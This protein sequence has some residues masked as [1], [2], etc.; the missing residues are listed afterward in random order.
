M[1]PIYK[2]LA[3]AAMTLQVSLAL[4]AQTYDGE[5]TS[6]TALSAE[7]LDSLRVELVAPN[8]SGARDLIK[9]GECEI[10]GSDLAITLNAANWIKG[11]TYSVQVVATFGTQTQVIYALDV[12]V[13]YY[14]ALASDPQ[15]Y[16][17]TVTVVSTIGDGI[18]EDDLKKA[19]SLTYAQLKAKR[20]AGELV[21]GQYYRITDYVTT[22]A[23]YDNARSAGHAFD[24]IVLALSTDTLSEEA[25]AIQHAGDT[26]FAD[27]NLNG[28]KV[29][30]CIDNDTNRFDWADATNGKG[31]IYR[32]VDEYRNDMPFDFKNVQ[33]RRWAVTDVTKDDV[34]IGNASNFVYEDGSQDIRYGLHGENYQSGNLIFEVDSEDSAYYYA[35]SW[36]NEDGDI[37]DAS[38]VGQTLQN[39]EGY[40]NGVHDNAQTMS[41]VHDSEGVTD[42]LSCILPNNVIVAT[43]SYEDGIFYGIYSNTF[44]N[45]CYSNTFGNYCYSNTFGNDCY[46]NTFGNGC[47]SN[48]FGNGCYSNTFGN[49]CYS[50][51]FGNYCS[52][53]TFGN[54]CSSNTFGNYC[55]S[56]TFGNYCYSNTFGNYCYSNTFGNYCSFNTFG[57]YCSFNTFGNDCYYNTF[58]NDSQN[59]IILKDHMR[60]V[61]LEAGVQYAD[62]TC[63]ETTSD[64]AYGQNVLVHSGVV[65]AS[66][67]R[68]TCSIDDAGNDFLTEFGTVVQGTIS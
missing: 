60:Y 14:E 11:A 30:Y 51:T 53:N 23:G 28:W 35:F 34:S 45:Y 2:S 52:S 3:L 13:P 48:T 54:D 67:A 5:N 22:V 31:V 64:S 47:S 68:K 12:T 15:E 46:F 8:V 9:S 36:V 43:H 27:C 40:V 21:P 18:G 16:E 66:K 33:F 38:I 10:Y 39:D 24:I 26:Y 41:A 57:N 7:V 32:L 6:E 63:A 4:N 56:N 17:D 62:I 19:I 42:E 44:G 37:E 55:Y 1:K 29:W 49:G 20:D 25:H 59:D 58:G 61:T 50:N 65:G